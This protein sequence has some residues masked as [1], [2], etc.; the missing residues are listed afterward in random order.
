MMPASPRGYG[1]GGGGSGGG[2]FS[3]DDEDDMMNDDEDSLPLTSYGG[4]GDLGGV[5]SASGTGGRGGSRRG[6]GGN[7][8]GSGG[9][10]GLAPI[11][12]SQYAS[13][14]QVS[15][16]GGGGGAGGGSRGLRADADTRRFGE[17]KGPEGALKGSLVWCARL[18]LAI[19]PN[20][21]TARRLSQLFEEVSLNLYLVG[22]ARKR[23]SHTDD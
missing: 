22:G 7:G 1:S 3:D 10:G 14:T 6:I 19:S 2:G 4:S 16:S 20:E 11:F 17:G 9:G 13:G 8:S 15:G 23:C 12:A 18:S 21:A 5:G